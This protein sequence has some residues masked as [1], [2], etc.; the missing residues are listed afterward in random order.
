MANRN[1]KDDYTNGYHVV[2][3]L[4]DLPEEK[5][6]PHE[7]IGLIRMTPAV[8]FSLIALRGYLLLMLLLVLYRVLTLAGVL[9]HK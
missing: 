5:R 2:H 3:P 8:R 7:E 4:D 6:A 9:G 1:T